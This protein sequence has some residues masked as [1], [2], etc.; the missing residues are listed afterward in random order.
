[1]Q[2]TVHPDTWENRSAI[3]FRH[4]NCVRKQVQDQAENPSYGKPPGIPSAGSPKGPRNDYSSLTGTRS[5]VSTVSCS[6]SFAVWLHSVPSPDPRQNMRS[7]HKITLI[8]CGQDT[9]IGNCQPCK[10][11]GR[12]SLNPLSPPLSKVTI[13]LSWQCRVTE[14]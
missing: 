8:F 12:K 13:P 7:W 11:R 4:P 3:L 9:H 1:M 10:A 2:L 6:K 14:H 5:P